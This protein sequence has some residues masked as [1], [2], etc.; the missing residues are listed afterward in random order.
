MC[1]HSIIIVDIDVIIVVAM[2][3]YLC[4][5]HVSIAAVN[6]KDL[7]IT[8]ETSIGHVIDLFGMLG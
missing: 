1:L 3:S 2:F 5:N 8:C 7:Q 4:I 6:V